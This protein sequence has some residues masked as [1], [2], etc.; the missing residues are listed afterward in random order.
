M[1]VMEYFAMRL[2]EID[3]ELNE[4]EK[5]RQRILLRIKSVK[6]LSD[7]SS[8]CSETRAYRKKCRLV[9]QELKFIKKTQKNMLRTNQ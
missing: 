8:I 2:K 3:D 7:F 1:N 6:N 4:L 9:K 5:V